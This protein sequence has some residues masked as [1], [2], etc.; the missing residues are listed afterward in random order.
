M[1]EKRADNVYGKDKESRK[2]TWVFAI[3]LVMI[4]GSTSY[5]LIRLYGTSV[6]LV[7]ANTRSFSQQTRAKASVLNE[8]L[9]WAVSEVETLARS[10][11]LQTYYHNKA[12][13]MSLEYGLSL[14]LV[15]MND[16]FKRYLETPASSGLPVFKQISFFSLEEGRILAQVPPRDGQGSDPVQAV[17]TGENFEK[18]LAFRTI[19]T[20][21][22]C[23]VFLIRSLTYSGE[24]K[25]LLVLELNLETVQKKIALGAFPR[26]DDFTGLM[27]SEGTLIIGPGELL[28]KNFHDIFGLSPETLTKA[29]VPRIA[30]NPAGTDREPLIAGGARLAITPLYLVA[31]APRSKH[32]G[33]H[34]PILWPL[35][36]VLGMG[37]LLLMLAYIFKS[38]TDR[39][40]IFL[41]L[42]D[43]RKHLEERVQSRTAEMTRAN[44]LL[45]R[46]IGERKKVEEALRESEERYREFAQCLPQIVFEMDL[47]GRFTFGNYSGLRAFA[48]TEEDFGNGIQAADIFVLEER[49][50][51]SE[52][53]N[54]VL[55]GQNL[56]GAQYTAVRKDGT[57]FPVMIYTSPIIRNNTVVGARGV[58]VDL[59]ELKAA[60]EALLAAHEELEQRV[61]ERTAELHSAYQRLVREVSERKRAEITLLERERFLS[62]VFESIQDGISVL[63]RDCNIVRVNPTVEQAFS[64]LHPL[65]G[66]KC[67]EIYYGRIRKC[68]VCPA[69]TAMETGKSS[70]AVVPKR[71]KEGNA[72]SWLH[73]FAYPLRDK[74]TG[75][76]RGVIVIS[77]DVTKSKSLEEQ[78]RH[79][80]KME[81]IGTLAGGIAHDFNN[82]LTIISGYTELAIRTEG[83]GD[84]SNGDLRPVLEAAR[85][86]AGLVK[87]ILTFSKRVESEPCP[88][89]MNQLVK[90]TEK[91]LSKTIPKMIKICL[92]LTDNLKTIN[93]DPAQM[94]Q[95]ILNL[96][97]NSRDAMP[98]GGELLIRTENVVLDEEYCTVHAEVEPGEYILLTV[99]DTGRGMETAVMERIFEPF[100]TT[101]PSGEGTGLGLAMVFGIVKSHGG[102]V[103]C[104]SEPGEGTSFKVYLS[105]M[106]NGVALSLPPASEEV[107]PR[108][109]ETILMA[110]DEEMIR[111]LGARILHKAGYTVLTAS[112]GHEAL[113]VYNRERERISL[114]LLDLIMPGMGGKQCL[115]EILKIDPDMKVI[116]ASGFPEK[117][118]TRGAIGAG[119]RGFINKPFKIN[120]MLRLVRKVLDEN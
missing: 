17:A 96:A 117:T 18:G 63:D 83:W 21:N 36:I 79:A 108:G 101:K 77:R 91:L 3:F 75:S 115:Q 38:Y 37:G 97:V 113:Q 59:T 6:R 2:Y 10:K 109:T 43:S 40:R 14:S 120:E 16:K 5:I 28:G 20:E 81:A 4:L 69:K 34:S 30:T 112:N 60:E 86:G 13:G 23:R 100:Y 25:G 57:T 11:T 74:E 8:Y 52:D 48:Y 114:V 104:Y 27:T 33:R 111:G 7:E 44:R 110:D 92:E 72:V 80:Q 82:L 73:V 35:A 58:C 9:S 85:R 95:I 87:Q 56:G 53:I 31:V 66:R 102:H 99:S 119:A 62:D 41:E 71:D 88:M 89:D 65:I 54:L 84:Q 29:Q 22:L 67:H 116:L 61:K 26:N 105:A 64:H 76:L 78:L 49:E 39:L 1:S 98:D 15:Q 12:L 103:A 90:Q 42:E 45:R 94:E 50:R 46:E 68:E 55:Q 24:Q 19:C 106:K 32:L 51:A 107:P 70:S 47:E 118:R 93:A